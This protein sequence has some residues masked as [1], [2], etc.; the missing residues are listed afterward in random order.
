[1]DIK[2]DIL[3][4]ISRYLDHNESYSNTLLISGARQ[5]G[6]TTLVQQA[7]QNRPHLFINL[8]ESVTLAE[9][10]NAVTSFI[11]LERLFL[12]E[13]N[14]KPSQGTILVIDEAQ[15]S[16]NLGRWVR[17]FKE[18]WAHQKVILLGSILSNLFEEGLPYPIGRVEEITLR[19][20]SFKEFLLATN[21]L[22]LREIL[23]SASLEKNLSEDDRESFIPPYLE[24]LQTGGMPEV[25]KNFVLT[26]K[27]LPTVWDTLLRQYAFDVERYLGEIYR[28]LFIATVN[29]IAEMTCYPVKNSQIISTDSPFYR[30]LPSL[31]EVLEKWHLVFKVGAKTKVPE[32]AGRL[33]SKRY[34]FDVGLTNFLINR[35]LPLSWQKRP[36]VGN[37]IFGKLQENF[38][39]NQ[40]IS[41]HPVPMANLSYYRDTRNSREIDFIVN[42]KGNYVPIEVKSQAS[43]GR[44]SLLPMIHFLEQQ[45]MKYGILVYNGPA[46]KLVHHRKTIF[47]IPPFLLSKIF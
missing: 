35:S 27:P 44:N 19:P 16:K 28:S 5:V 32:S 14:F 23:E 20:F 45:G 42:I 37:I 30:R 10:I 26:E 34:L 7:V 25:V 41:N 33:A 4:E 39:C 2:R 47:A 15:E 13:L 3:R 6:K 11:D 38:V 24:Y 21:R 43:V 40:I 31:L 17:F 9:K 12:R 1:M 22:G 36:E 29:R 8:F 18:K 46:K